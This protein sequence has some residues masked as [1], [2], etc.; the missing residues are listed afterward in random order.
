MKSFVVFVYW[1]RLQGRLMSAPSL[2]AAKSAS[3]IAYAAMGEGDIRHRCF[4]H[5]DARTI[6]VFF[7]THIQL[8][9]ATELQIGHRLL[10]ALSVSTC[11][12]LICSGSHACSVLVDFRTTERLRR[13][14]L[15]DGVARRALCAV[16]FSSPELAAG[17]ERRRG[18]MVQWVRAGASAWA[19]MSG[20]KAESISSST[21]ARS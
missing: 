1:I 8:I 10:L 18:Q 17:L 20:A 7:E 12:N 14:W 6:Q 5:L 9:E 15:C 19:W 13:C 11:A 16:V 21:T 2:L 3:N 4:R